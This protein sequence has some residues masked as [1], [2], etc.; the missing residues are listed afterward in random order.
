[1]IRLFFIFLTVV[2]FNEKPKKIIFK[3]P[4]L[5]SVTNLTGS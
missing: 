4:N 5:L 3:I 2:K 1:M